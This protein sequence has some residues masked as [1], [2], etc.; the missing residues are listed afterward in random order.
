MHVESMP[1]VCG[2]DQSYIIYRNVHH[3]KK[4]EADAIE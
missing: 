4:K 2:G 3:E 1:F